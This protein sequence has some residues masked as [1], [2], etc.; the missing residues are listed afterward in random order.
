MRSFLIL[1]VIAVVAPADSCGRATT[2]QQPALAAAPINRFDADI[3]AFGDSDRLKPPRPGGVVFVGSS[4][5][6]LWPDLHGDFP[7][8]NVIQRGFGGSRLDEVLHYAP[9]I[10]VPYKPSLVVLYA[11]DNDL[12]EGR[13]AKAVFDDYKSFVRLVQTALPETKIAYISIKPSASRWTLVD[14]MR[15]ANALVKQY[16]SAHPGLM[17]VDVFSAMLGPDGK[18][19]ANLFVSDSLHMNASGYAIWRQLVMPVVSATGAQRGR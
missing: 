10:V 11:G 18:P 12:A 5:I 17:Y 19:R 2:V 14:E 15:A 16:A 9:R 1:A 4:S 7:G 3:R 6:R 13:T 8:T